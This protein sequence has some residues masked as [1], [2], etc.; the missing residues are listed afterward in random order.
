MFRPLASALR[1]TVADGQLTI[2][3]H[4]G[5]PHR[6]G[7]GAGPEI[8]VRLA[9]RAIGWRLFVHP[10]LALG[11]GFMDGRIVMEKGSI[12]D[13]LDL[14]L[15]QADARPL[16]R[17]SGSIDRV[18]RAWKYL[19]QYNPASRSRRNVAHHYDLDAA[20]YAL[21]LDRDRQ[22]SCA[23]WTAAALAT[24]DLDAAQAAK[25]AH[26][27]D[28]LVVRPG[29]R[30]LDIGSGWGGLALDIA[31]RAETEV[32]GITLSEE[33]F[34]IARARAADAG[35][36]AR[37]SFALA[38]YRSIR[39][40]FDRIVSVGMLE[41]VG[42]RYY[43]RYFRTIADALTDDGVAVVHAIGRFDGPAVTAPFIRKYIFPGGY[44]PALSEVL[45]S[46]E[47]SGLY[48]TD[49]EIL[50]LHYAE[51]LRA[52]RR[53]FLANRDTARDRLG[54]RFC[55]MWEFYLAAS[56]AG[57]RYQKLMVFQLQLAKRLDTLP[58]TRDY[59]LAPRDAPVRPTVPA[60][61]AETARRDAA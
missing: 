27:I 20:L 28:K 58:L 57:F 22:Y 50:R 8:R 60:D 11:E 34:R 46:V 38:D 21:F 16:P 59:L 42:V 48:L 15:R 56:E 2:V 25:K 35:V 41:H 31:R 54:E 3:D 23:Y 53:R 14:V 47:R 12:Y 36:D 39:G 4:A 37:V 26:I 61:L 24:D 6:F 30:V 10:Q 55:R 5:R 17:I 29:Q 51:T 40:P 1:K 33:Q 9:D 7:D 18:S 49:V 43:D 19:Q 13:L 32:L 45:P 52:W 44:I